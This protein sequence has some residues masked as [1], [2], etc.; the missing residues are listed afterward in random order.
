MPHAG[1]HDVPPALS[2]QFT[3]SFFESFVTV[4]FTVWSGEPA[5]I[6]ENLFVIETSML[7]CAP[8]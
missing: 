1:E 7:A 2:V 5:T 8:A 3:P 6:D 4:T